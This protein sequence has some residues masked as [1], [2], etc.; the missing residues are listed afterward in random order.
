MK[1]IKTTI[2]IFFIG[3]TLFAQAPQGFNYQTI[4]R[5]DDGSVLENQSVSFRISILQGS[6]SGTAVYVETQSGST[7]KFGLVYFEVGNGTVVSGNF[8]SV[9][10]G[11]NSYYL[12]IEMDDAGGSNYQSYG[13]SQLV[14][15]PY[16]LYSQ[17]AG[18]TFSGDYND[19]SNAPTNLSDF[20]N[21]VGFIDSEVDGSVTNEIQTLS[22]SN[23]TLTLSNGGGSVNISASSSS[24]TTSGVGAGGSVDLSDLGND[25]E[26]VLMLGTGDFTVNSL[27]SDANNNFY[28]AGGYSNEASIGGN[29]LTWHNDDSEY[30]AKFNSSGTLVWVKTIYSDDGDEEMYG[31]VDCEKIIVDGAGNVFVKGTFR[32]NT[33][34]S[35]TQV[36]SDYNEKDFILKFD[37][38]GNVGWVKTSLT[39]PINTIVDIASLSEGFYATESGVSISKYSSSGTK[40]WS[41]T[42]ATS[43][44]G[45]YDNITTDGIFTDN[46]SNIYICGNAMGNVTIGTASVTIE[47]YYAEERYCSKYDSNGD[48]L[49]HVLFTEEGAKSPNDLFVDKNGN[50]F[51]TNNFVN[52]VTIEGEE[53]GESIGNDSYILKYT[54][55]GTFEWATALGG[56]FNIQSLCTDANNSIIMA[57]YYNS[58]MVLNDTYYKPFQNYSPLAIIFDENGEYTGRKEFKYFGDGKFEKITKLENGDLLILINAE[59]PFYNNQTRY[60]KGKYLLKF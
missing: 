39:D 50:I 14:S 26:A 25:Y 20:N 55:T 36:N 24:S 19:L 60:L 40:E 23:G 41:K 7:N 8:S 10:W 16:S 27:A 6:S 35:G 53:I 37:N 51:Y 38:A 2:L 28:I 42:A 4:I 48:Y 45:E 18:N 56:R 32:Y 46:S 43:A 30:I 49:L 58:S 52:T 22:Y 33:N 12:K 54:N 57:G 47:G 29:A 1:K 13:T 31:E 5:N 17:K 59:K 34:F 11:S 15:V 44:G 21:D 3:I 9:N